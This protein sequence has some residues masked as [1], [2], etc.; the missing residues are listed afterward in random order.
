MTW[1]DWIKKHATTFGMQRPDALEMLGEWAHV[2]AGAGHTPQLMAEATRRVALDPPRGW[3]GHLRALHDAARA[4]SDARRPVG[5]PDPE[6]PP[7]CKLCDGCGVVSVPGPEAAARGVLMP[8]GVVCRCPLGLFIRRDQ[9]N[10][11]A[12]KRGVQQTIEEYEDEVRA[13]HGWDWRVVLGELKAQRDRELGAVERARRADDSG[14]L[15]SGVAPAAFRAAIGRAR[16]RA[17]G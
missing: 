17:Q 10:R 15:P 14:R 6:G 16:G 2:F 1:A 13:A 4:I 11:W 3:A 12:G 7:G 9:A 8:R 5:R